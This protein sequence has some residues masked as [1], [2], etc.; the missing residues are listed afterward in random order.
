[1]SI[2]N[3]VLKAVE[4]KAVEKHKAPT[5]YDENTL[6]TLTE[7][8]STIPCGSALLCSGTAAESRMIEQVDGTDFSHTAMIVRFHDDQTG[9]SDHELYVWTADTVDKLEDQIDKLSDKKH[10][11]T[12]L[13]KLND[14]L[15]SLDKL[16][17]SPDGS[18]YR[19]AVARL[20]GVK[21]DEKQLWS[22]MYEY[23]GTPFPPTK[24]EFMHWL[25]GQLNINTGMMNSFCAQMLANTYQ[26][27]GWLS[28]KHPPNHYN[29]GSFAKTEQINNE[30][31]SGAQL[32]K[33]EYFK[34]P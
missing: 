24:Q 4:D 17:P 1:M 6:K 32:L 27:M 13:L 8:A 12:H 15:A 16:Y 30:L 28:K 22:V 29:P 21:V 31:L 25:E 10:P 9:L 23:D 20:T 2:I 19:F 14:Y 18:K 3:D 7:L 26:K 11:G 33:P 34:L 5:D